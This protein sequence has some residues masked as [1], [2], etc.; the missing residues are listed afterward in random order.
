MFTSSGVSACQ[1]SVFMPRRSTTQSVANAVSRIIAR[2]V[3]R[4]PPSEIF[5]SNFKGRPFV[6]SFCAFVI[7]S[8]G[9]GAA[10]FQMTFPFLMSNFLR[11]KR[12]SSIVTEKVYTLFWTIFQLVR[13]F[14]GVGT[15]GKTFRYWGQAEGKFK[16]G[17]MHLAGKKEAVACS[18]TACPACN[19][20]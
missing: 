2:E 16:L 9:V 11:A 19:D 4:I 8:V 6:W 7:T 3:A 20:R 15:Q 12:E 17:K 13:W 18:R 1:R 14:L 5:H 10:I